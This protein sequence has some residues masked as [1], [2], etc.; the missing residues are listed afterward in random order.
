MLEIPADQA[1]QSC[2]PAHRLSVSVPVFKV[3]DWKPQLY[4][5]ETVICNATE[6]LTRW[7]VQ[8]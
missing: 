1:E 6:F 5:V 8:P 2:V 3:T 4:N 7:T